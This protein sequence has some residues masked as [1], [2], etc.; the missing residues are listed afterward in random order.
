MKDELL[1]IVDDHNQVIGQEWRSVINKTKELHKIRAVWFFVQNT[2]G[3]LWIPR[4]A[5]CKRVRPLELDG[6]AVGC[7]SAGETYEQA[8][9]R[10]TQEEI[11]IHLQKDDYTFLGYMHP[12]DGTL[13]HVYVYHTILNETPTYDQKEFCEAFWLSPQEIIDLW[14][15]GEKMKPSLPKI[16]KRF[17]L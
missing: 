3:Q 16:I 1:D 12:R 15:K 14:D 2:K 7:V 9:I 13:C 6:S 11:N 4:R 17:F 10:E 8:L 5:A